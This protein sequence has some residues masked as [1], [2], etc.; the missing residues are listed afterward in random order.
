MASF[1]SILPFWRSIVSPVT[2]SPLPTD[3]ARE[4]HDFGASSGLELQ[5]GRL[6]D[7]P[8]ADRPALFSTRSCRA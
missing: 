7:D 4:S 1:K 5:F 3:H 6:M 8:V 2:G